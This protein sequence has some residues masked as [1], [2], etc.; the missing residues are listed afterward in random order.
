MNSTS[1]NQ[2]E[3]HGASRRSG[4]RC[5]GLAP[6]PPVLVAHVLNTLPDSLSRREE[7]LRALAAGI[8]P[9]EESAAWVRALQFHL[10]EHQRLRFDW[11][12]EPDQP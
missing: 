12:A 5:G 7:L 4:P 8:P 3:K 9:G 6:V 1:K 11:P 10:Q 2:P